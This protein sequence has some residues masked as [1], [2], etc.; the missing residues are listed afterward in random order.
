MND[1]TQPP[2]FR[3]HFYPRSPRSVTAA[4]KFA[5]AALS[6]W[7]VP[8]E[9]ARDI[10]VCVSELTANALAHGVPPG[11]GFQVALHLLPGGRVH[12]EVHDSGPGRPRSGRVRAGRSA[13]C[14]RG[15]V[16]VEALSDAWGVGAREV[17]KVVWCDFSV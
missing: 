7:G 9:R 14:G 11:R 13:V 12:V 8:L 4:R 10:E 3:E 17:G 15:L 1:G 6:D 5:R 2:A 16:V